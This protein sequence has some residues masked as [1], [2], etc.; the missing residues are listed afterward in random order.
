MGEVNFAIRIPN[1]IKMK[2]NPSR[3]A[4]PALLIVLAGCSKSVSEM[5][6]SDVAD[7]AVRV[8]KGALI[9]LYNRSLTS[10]TDTQIVCHGTGLYR[11]GGEF[12]TR[13]VA[14]IDSDGDELIRYDTSEF[15]ADQERQ[16][17]AE[18]NREAAQAQQQ[19]EQ[20]AQQAIDQYT[21]EARSLT[22]N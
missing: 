22:G 19:Y 12:P 6:C 13:F 5:S 11:N 3:W 2:S 17:N 1:K 18:F 16:A 7:E 15:Q 9:K 14:F 20:S 8:S 4:L 10:K 21:S